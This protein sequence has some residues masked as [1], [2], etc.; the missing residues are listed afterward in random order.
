IARCRGLP[1]ARLVEALR[2]DQVQRWRRGERLRAEVYLNAFPDVREVDEDALVLIW[3]EALLRFEAGEAPQ[4]GGYRARFPR[5]AEAL[6]LQFQLQVHLQTIAEPTPFAA[7]GPL[8]A[9]TLPEVQGYDVLGEI[10]RGGMGVVFRARQTALNR[11]VA[12]K[13][14]LAG[15]L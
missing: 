9:P 7:C 6:T 12:L 11:T 5:H 1:P 14:I 2:A 13:M 10:G 3:G 15:Q 4:P 8:S